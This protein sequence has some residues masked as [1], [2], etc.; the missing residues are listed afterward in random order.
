MA[1]VSCWSIVLANVKAIGPAIIQASSKL[2]VSRLTKFYRTSSAAAAALSADGGELIYGQTT[3]S[4]RR[5][6][7]RRLDDAA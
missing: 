1:F 2:T 6:A 3:A 7:E 4:S 5:Q